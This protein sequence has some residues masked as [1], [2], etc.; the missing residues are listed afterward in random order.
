MAQ[1]RRSPEPAKPTFEQGRRIPAGVIGLPSLLAA[2]IAVSNV[3]E[4]RPFDRGFWWSASVVVLGLAA[5]AVVAVVPQSA[6]RIA[7]DRR[8]LHVSGELR[9]SASRIGQIKALKGG[10][11]AVQSWPLSR[12]RGLKMP[13]KQNLY[14]GLY[15]FGPAVGV[16]EVDRSGKR[17][18]SWLLPT[19]RPQELEAALVAAR[20][21]A[22]S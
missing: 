16:E 10:A 3:L 9:L 1:Q 15:G 4:G 14:G 2:G 13:S 6:K 7:V 11:A 12:N 19:S 22:R 18:S 20:D 21:A 17:V 8:G 5:V